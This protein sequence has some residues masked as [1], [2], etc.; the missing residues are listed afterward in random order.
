MVGGQCCHYVRQLFLGGKTKMLEL[1]ASNF[2]EE[3]NKTSPIIV[4]FWASWCGPCK[5]MAPVF[6]EISKDYSDDKL[7]FAKCSV[8]DVGNQLYANNFNIT[9][10]P[11]FSICLSKQQRTASSIS[12][13]ST[14]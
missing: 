12:I 1:D 5:M 10:I 8:E 3:T 11:L 14:L 4:D 13:H 2:E 7:R 6:E 9:G